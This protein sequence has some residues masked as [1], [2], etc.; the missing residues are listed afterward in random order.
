[1]VLQGGIGTIEEAP[2]RTLEAG[3]FSCGIPGTLQKARVRWKRGA[4]QPIP[5]LGGFCGQSTHRQGGGEVSSC[6]L[7]APASCQREKRSE[8]KR[9]A[10]LPV[11]RRHP[12][13]EGPTH[14][15]ACLRSCLPNKGTHQDLVRRRLLHWEGQDLLR[16]LCQR[17]RPVPLDAAG[18]GAALLQTLPLDLQALGL[19]APRGRHLRVP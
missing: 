11:L 4:A 5:H 7:P 16:S 18:Q 6:S 12:P 15:G 19:T 1:M 13:R 14:A 9:G 2:K 10:T 17:G 3:R 8:P